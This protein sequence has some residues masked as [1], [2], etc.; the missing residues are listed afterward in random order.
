MEPLGADNFGGNCHGPALQKI[1]GGY[2]LYSAK[3]SHTHRGFNATAVPL[4]SDL[5]RVQVKR[6]ETLF[7]SLT[8]PLE[9]WPQPYEGHGNV[10]VRRFAFARALVLEH[11]PGLPHRQHVT[12]ATIN[13]LS[14]AI[15]L[16]VDRYI[17]SPEG[18]E[19][20]AA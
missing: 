2:M 13:D 14:R 9:S 20:R 5:L 12:E 7:T 6:F 15:V 11:D 17:E 18:G 10:R 19:R 4:D 1:D 3:T 8:V 16:L